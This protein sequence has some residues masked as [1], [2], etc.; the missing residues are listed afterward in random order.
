MMGPDK[1]SACLLNLEL[2]ALRSAGVE[3]S[4]IVITNRH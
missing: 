1:I 4:S 2:S 3:P